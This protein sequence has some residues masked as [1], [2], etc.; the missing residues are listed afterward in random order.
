MRYKKGQSIWISAV[1]Y[2]L[3]TAIIMVLVLETGV[4]LL[5]RLKDKSTFVYSKDALLSVNQQIKQLASEGKGSQRVI[6]IDLPDGELKIANNKIMWQLRTEA[7]II[8]RGIAFK[9]G[10]V[11]IASNLDVS[12]SQN[13]TN[14]VLENDHIRLTFLR[15]GN[16]SNYSAINTLTLMQNIEFQPSLDTL[17]PELTFAVNGV[18]TGNGYTYLEETGSDMESATFIA[19]VNSSTVDFKLKITLNSDSNYVIP[20]IEII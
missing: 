3:V 18:S 7:P 12:A 8:E 6:P 19:L 1:L 13:S 17:N 14:H 5:D 4:P 16:A 20:E 10:D 2:L 11:T 9:S 15:V